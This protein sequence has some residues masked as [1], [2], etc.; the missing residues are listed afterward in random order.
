MN[1]NKSKIASI[2][3]F[4]LINCFA[5]I[6]VTALLAPLLSFATAGIVIH[7]AF[8]IAIITGFIAMYLYW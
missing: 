7:I 5:I 8:L 1:I 2:C 4:I 6:I 3:F